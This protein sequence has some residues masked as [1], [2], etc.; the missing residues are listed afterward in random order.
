M[1]KIK[2]DKRPWGVEKI[3]ALN[4]KCSIKLL[5]VKPNQELSLQSHKHRQENWYFLDNARVQ[6]GDKK[7]NVKAGDFISVK[8][9]QKHRVI[10]K[11]NIARFIEISF[12]K[13][14]EKDEVRYEDRYGRATASEKE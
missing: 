12:G 14:D 2:I 4:K 3:F 8:K 10:S 7:F 5:T 11:S 6:V 9:R 1:V 13:F